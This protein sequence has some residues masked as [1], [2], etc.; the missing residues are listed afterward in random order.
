MHRHMFD[1]MNLMVLDGLVTGFV[2]YCFASKHFQYLL[3]GLFGPC[4]FLK[5][6]RYKLNGAACSMPGISLLPPCA[7]FALRRI[8]STA[9][10]V[11][12]SMAVTT[13]C[14]QVE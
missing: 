11:V 14:V 3:L 7:G 12:S 2:M 8:I 9:L 10:Y 5:R 13:L 4:A 1:S 6:E